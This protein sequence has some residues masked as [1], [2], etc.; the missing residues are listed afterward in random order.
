M[1]YPAYHRAMAMRIARQSLWPLATTWLTGTV[2]LWW[3]MPALGLA[4]LAATAFRGG[5]AWRYADA[6][7]AALIEARGLRV[8]EWAHSLPNVMVETLFRKYRLGGWSRG[9]LLRAE[10]AG[11]W[12]LQHQLSPFDLNVLDLDA[13]NV[14]SDL[15]GRARL[16]ANALAPRSVAAELAELHMREQALIRSLPTEV[17]YGFLTWVW[18]ETRARLRRLG[19]LIR[20]AHRAPQVPAAPTD[21]AQP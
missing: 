6:A 18:F 13:G 2:A 19:R 16:A 20:R 17:P 3:G 4:L 8:F 10:L 7:A 11:S 21:E 5:L 9:P 12:L 15:H 14:Q 1:E